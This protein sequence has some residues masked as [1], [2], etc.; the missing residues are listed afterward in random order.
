ML[1]YLTRR[2]LT[3]LFVMTAMMVIVFFGTNMIGDPVALLVDPSAN[4]AEIEAARVS[5]GL[6]QPIWFQFWA[7]LTNAFQGDFGKSFVFNRP[8]FDVIL[9]RLPATLELAAAAALIALLVGLPAGLYAG[10][11][12]DRIGAKVIMGVSIFGFSLPSFWVGI[13]LILL[14][15]VTFGWFPATGRGDTVELFGIRWSILT[16]DGISH[17]FLPALNLSLTKMAI[18]TRLVAAGTQEVRSQD[19]VRFARAKGV[20]GARLTLKHIGRNV[21]VPVITVIGIEIGHLI[22][23]SVV[24]ETIFAWP[25]VGRLVITSIFSLDRPVLV[26]Y[27]VMVTLMFV[28]INLIVDLLYVALDPRIKLGSTPD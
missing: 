18:V 5:L 28:L 24:T 14:F 6:D 9:E 17:L 22:A 3:A 21:M 1:E 13:V 10:L 12:P 19:F 8:V 4:Q 2:L 11:Y 26:A 23:Y 20:R 7:F 15:S 16:W 25:G 27:L